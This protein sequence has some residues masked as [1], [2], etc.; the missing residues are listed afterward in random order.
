M[1][2]TRIVD[3]VRE[4]CTHGAKRK[5]NDSCSQVSLLTP[6]QI[7]FSLPLSCWQAV[8]AFI[9]LLDFEKEIGKTPPAPQTTYTYYSYITNNSY[10]GKIPKGLADF[11]QI[12]GATYPAFQHRQQMRSGRIR[13]QN[14]FGGTGSSL[15]RL[16][17]SLTELGSYALAHL[18][19]LSQNLFS[20]NEKKKE[21]NVIE[22]ALEQRGFQD[23][24]LMLS[25]QNTIF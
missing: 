24:R 16:P 4:T 25:M 6:D 19:Q 23:V 17:A 1:G 18:L 5:A 9:R 8:E 14:N 7:I 13:F 22:L 21:K 10:M 11:Y 2:M 15:V 12:Q 3:E 20:D